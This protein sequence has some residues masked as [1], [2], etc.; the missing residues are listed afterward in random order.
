VKPFKE[1][2]IEG[3][4]T[5]VKNKA[6][7]IV[8]AERIPLDEIG[9]KVFVKRFQDF[10]LKLNSKFEDEYG[11]KLWPDEKEIMNAGVFNGSTSFIMAD[12]IPDKEL[13]K[14]KKSAGDIDIAFPKECAQDLFALLLDNKGKDII[15][16]MEYI[17]SN[18]DDGGKFGSTIIAIVKCTFDTVTIRAQV[19]FELSDFE[20]NKQTDYSKM[21]HS[22]SFKDAKAGMKG[23]ASKFLLRALVGASSEIKDGFVLLTPSS[24]AEKYKLPKSQPSSIRILSFGLD[25]GIGAKYELIKTKDGEPFKIDGKI[26][27]RQY[28]S[29]ERSYDKTMSYLI[30][31]AFGGKVDNKVIKPKQLHAFVDILDIMKKYMP[32]S[33]YPDVRDRLSAALYGNGGGMVQAIE[34]KYPDEDIKLKTAIY[35][36][37]CKTLKLQPNPNLD[38]WINYYMEKVHKK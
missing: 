31:I 36:Y 6:G 34:P 30:K 4:N 16:N 27:Y 26:A 15:P 5:T 7:D 25:Q 1:Y 14:Y 13:L 20:N 37:F 38:S 23:V 22:S 33:K 32:K 8:D 3:G 10:F 2:L 19:D 35:D 18:K 24:T 12:D 9:R 17:G 11:S 28:K 21:A 29:G